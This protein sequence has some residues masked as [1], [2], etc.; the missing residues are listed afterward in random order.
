MG[1]EAWLKRKRL[2]QAEAAALIQCSPTS[3]YRYSRAPHSKYFRRPD[4]ARMINIYVVSCG[5]VTPN[6][7]Y[8]LPALTQAECA[9]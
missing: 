2:T 9:A 1:F 5:E 6:D 3:I 8:T 4:D 7:F